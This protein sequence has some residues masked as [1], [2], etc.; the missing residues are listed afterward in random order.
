MGAT[1]STDK[2]VAAFTATSGKTMYALFEETYLSNCL[3]RQPHWSCYMIGELPAVLRHIFRVASNCEAGII[4][5]KGNRE[6]TPEGYIAGWLKELANPAEM[7]DRKFELYSTNNYMAPLPTDTFAWAKHAMA[8][9]GR[10]ADAEKLEKGEHLIV[11]LYDD[12]ELLA[13]VYDGIHFGANRII[14][15][16]KPVQQAQRIPALGYAPAKSKVVTMTVPSFVRVRG[17][18]HYRAMLDDC[19]HWRGN[20]S[21]S[22]MNSFL[23]NLWKDELLEPQTYRAKIRAYREA[24]RRAPEMPVDA[25]L[26]VDTSAVTDDLDQSVLDWVLANTTHAVQ[27]SEIHIE[28]PETNPALYQV[29]TLD[30]RFAR[31]AFGTDA[32]VRK[33]G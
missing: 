26:I 17:I 9:V 24:L 2:L 10:E 29:V 32:Q 13:A 12:A 33:A 22:F 11:S 27:G 5:G 18:Q 31:Y 30:S 15:S 1:V 16:V 7:A 19:G 3:P 14:K 8:T 23:C 20:P 28:L 4:K 25:K 21:R 6:I